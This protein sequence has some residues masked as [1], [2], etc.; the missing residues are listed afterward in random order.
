MNPI[1]K[2]LKDIEPFTSEL[3]EEYKAAIQFSNDNFG[4]PD[5]TDSLVDFECETE[6]L[7]D[8][9]MKAHENGLTF[10]GFIVKVLRDQIAEAKEA[11]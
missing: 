4:N 9:L 7:T 2:F 10:N 11:E 3:E 1:Q 5:E 8:T 6:L